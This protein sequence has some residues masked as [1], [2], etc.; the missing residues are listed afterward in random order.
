V[1]GNVIVV[2]E[3]GRVVFG[4]QLV[5]MSSQL[6]ETALGRYLEHIIAHNRY[7]QLQGFIRVENL[8]TLSWSRFTSRCAPCSSAHPSPKKTGLNKKPIL[9]RARCGDFSV[10]M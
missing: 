1:D 10:F 7:L 5:E 3:G 4:A 2:K 9:H 6:R 8:S